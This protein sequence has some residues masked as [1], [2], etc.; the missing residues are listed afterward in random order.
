[1][2][3]SSS[4]PP[5]D[6]TDAPTWLVDTI[7]HGILV[8][9]AYVSNVYVGPASGFTSGPPDLFTDAFADA[10]WV[11]GRLNGVEVQPALGVWVTNR[12]AP[13]AAGEIFAV[14]AAAIRYTEWGEGVSNR[15]V[16]EGL[17]PV[18]ACVGPMPT[19]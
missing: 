3:E 6:C 9:G 16:G 7:S 4:G 10:W 12:T 1:M 14:N 8:R 17:E 19:T 13:D 2:I 18:Q 5:A 15:I 11:A